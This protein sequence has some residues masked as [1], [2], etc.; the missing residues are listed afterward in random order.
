MQADKYQLQ[1]MEIPKRTFAKVSI[2]LIDELPTSHYGNKNI[3]MIVDHLNGWPIAKSMPNQEAATIANAI[4]EKHILE[5]GDL[6]F[7]V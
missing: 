4:F 5:H 3:L 1:M 7:F 2:D 6:N